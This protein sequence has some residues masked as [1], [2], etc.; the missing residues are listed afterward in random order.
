M[1]WDFIHTLKLKNNKKRQYLLSI[2]HFFFQFMVTL[3]VHLCECLRDL[4]FPTNTILNS[5]PSLFVK[6][7]LILFTATSCHTDF[8]QTYISYIPHCFLPSLSKL[9]CHSQVL[10]QKPWYKEPASSR[11]TVY[12]TMMAA[13]SF[14]ISAH[15]SCPINLESKADL[16]LWEAST[17]KKIIVIIDLRPS[18]QR[19]ATHN[20]SQSCLTQHQGPSCKYREV[21]M[22]T[23][24]AEHSGVHPRSQNHSGSPSVNI[25]IF[26]SFSYK[27]SFVFSTHASRS[28]QAA[29]GWHLYSSCSSSRVSI[30]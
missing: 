13:D 5:R 2:Y 21:Q 1:D 23:D 6:T 17:E 14:V 3:T 10:N 8:R 9:S 7:C 28:Q 15:S 25:F 27:Y 11:P 24:K 16:H 22:V 4:L 20:H 18:F 29:S 26:I 12:I 30:F 19:V